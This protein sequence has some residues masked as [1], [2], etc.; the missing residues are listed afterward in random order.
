M[1]K[2]PHQNKGNGIK[3]TL[4]FKIF[5]ESMPS[6]PPRGSCESEK[7]VFAPKISEPVH[8]CRWGA[9]GV[10]FYDKAE[11]YERHNEMYML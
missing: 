6:D 3:E 7:F 4:F 5:W 8:L 1:H 10:L 11:T 9:G 2:N